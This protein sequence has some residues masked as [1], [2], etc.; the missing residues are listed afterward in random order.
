MMASK[1]GA[2]LSDYVG[3]FVIRFVFESM[4][5]AIARTVFL[6]RSLACGC[7]DKEGYPVLLYEVSLAENILVTLY[8]L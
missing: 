3:N 7:Q 2:G 6:Y 8:A 1:Y 4:V 5:T